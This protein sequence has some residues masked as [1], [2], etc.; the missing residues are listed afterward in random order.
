[1]SF[2][3]FPDRNV[4]TTRKI[5]GTVIFFSGLLV[6]IILRGEKNKESVVKQSQPSTNS[7]VSGWRFWQRKEGMK[8]SDHGSYDD[9]ESGQP[10]RAVH[11]QQHTHGDHSADNSCSINH[12]SSNGQLGHSSSGNGSGITMINGIVGIN[13]NHNNHSNHSQ[14]NGHSVSTT[15]GGGLEQRNT[16]IL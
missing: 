12:A 3:M 2:L 5:V 14:H 13:N 16:F 1:M 7:S 8:G 6:K 4:L 10:L 11:H 15:G 9:I